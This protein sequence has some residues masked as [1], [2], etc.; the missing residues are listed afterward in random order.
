MYDYHK[1]KVVEDMTKQGII[2]DEQQAIEI[3]EAIER[4]NDGTTLL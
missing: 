2:T 1:Q 4:G 3:L